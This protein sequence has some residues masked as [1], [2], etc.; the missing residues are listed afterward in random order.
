MK[1]MAAHACVLA[2]ALGVSGCTAVLP[3]PTPPASVSASSAASAVAVAELTVTVD[4]AFSQFYVVSG[5]A[6]VGQSS[7]SGS[8][9]RVGL[10]DATT[11]GALMLGTARQVG[12]I[13]IGVQV[14]DGP[15]PPL[16]AGWQ[17]VAEVPFEPAG[18]VRMK[19]WDPSS[20]ETVLP[21]DA[22]KTFRVRYAIADADDAGSVSFSETGADLPERYLVQFWP[23]SP[24]AA[25][26]VREDSA[27]GQYW[28]F[29]LESKAL[30]AR[31][32][33]L[34]AEQRFPAAVDFTLAEHPETAARIRAGDHRYTLGIRAATYWVDPRPE[35]PDEMDELII[36]HAERMR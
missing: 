16:D 9:R 25:E 21:L 7:Y 27:I 24:A 10:C 19:G 2:V 26:V 17:D 5:D 6:Y 29:S 34:A 36:E 4:A 15:P 31:V 14:F 13:P 35:S 18:A 11:P 3:E 33:V 1:W 20:T 12:P 23:A 32:S 22:A 30:A 28:N 8:G